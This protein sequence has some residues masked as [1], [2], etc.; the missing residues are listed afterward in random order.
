MP[1]AYSLIPLMGVDYLARQLPKFWL[2]S[3]KLLASVSDPF[4]Y[5]WNLFGTAHLGIASA[6]ILSIDGVIASQVV[7]VA[8][9][10][11][12]AI[13]AVVRIAR[14]DLAKL[15]DHPRALIA[16]SAGT[17]AL[18]GAAVATLYVAMGAAA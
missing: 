10:T 1:I 8:L 9:G 15:T 5:G 2:N 14:R 16:V 7:I 13:Y 6:Q 18:V 3:P 4:A 11:A 17:W 12:G